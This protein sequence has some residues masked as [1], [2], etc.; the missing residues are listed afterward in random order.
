[1]AA[2]RES[3]WM[4]YGAYGT[5]GKLI[6]DAPCAGGIGWSSRDAIRCDWLPSRGNMG[7]KLALRLDAPGSTESLPSVSAVVIGP[8][9][10]SRP[11]A[12][13]GPL[14]ARRCFLHR[15]ER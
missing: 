14:P 4:L 13:A 7:S 2:L 8:A 3:R 12:C 6:L 10:T 11:S 5:T 9:P 1:M 15:P